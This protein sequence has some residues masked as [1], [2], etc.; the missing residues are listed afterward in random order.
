MAVAQRRIRE[1]EVRRQQ[2]LEAAREVFFLKG[3]ENATIEDIAQKTELSKGAIYLYFPSKEE[4]YFTL[5][6]EG[7]LILQEMLK[8]AADADLPADT[9]LR[10]MGQAY[11]RFYEQYPGFFRMLFLYYMSPSREQ[12]VSRELCDS[13][14]RDAKESLSLVA[15][16]VDKGIRDGLF[17]A[18]NPVD[19]AIMLWT[20]Q[21]GMILLG[22][23]G[24]AEFLKLDSPV[25]R[26]HD[27]FIE[28]MI[29]SL[30]AG[31]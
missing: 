19:F 11:L 13:C 31:R 3:F 22:E 6:H 25:E 26:L 30:K 16:V 7:S 2:I 5:M 10:R 21:N 8:K 14:E 18:C 28:S 17:R 9:L 4:I 24:D 1:K 29:V 15:G 20:C 27:L 23:R 12:K